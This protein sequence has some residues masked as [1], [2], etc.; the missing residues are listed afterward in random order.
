MLELALGETVVGCQLVN[1]YMLY[2]ITST[3]RIFTRDLRPD[4]LPPQV[5]V[6]PDETVTVNEEGV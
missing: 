6:V 5:T 2:M 1:N 4:F 3:G